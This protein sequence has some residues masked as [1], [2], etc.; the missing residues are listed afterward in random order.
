LLQVKEEIA[1]MT[2]DFRYEK[3][4]IN[5]KGIASVGIHLQ[6]IR[7]VL[8]RLFTYAVKQDLTETQLAALAAEGTAYENNENL[9]QLLQQL[10]TQ[11]ESSVNGLKQINPETLTKKRTV[12]RAQLPATLQGLLFHAAEHTMRHT[13]QLLV[14]IKA[15]V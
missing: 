13:G 15:V 12:V 14:T 8:D 9:H 2:I 6:N 5:Q 11:I 10:N 4:W 3:L 1:G 7:C